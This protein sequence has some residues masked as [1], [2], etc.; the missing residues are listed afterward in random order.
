[1]DDED[2]VVRNHPKT[3]GKWP[4]SDP[5]QD[6]ERE[7]PRVIPISV[8]P[9]DSPPLSLEQEGHYAEPWAICVDCIHSHDPRPWW[10]RLFWQLQGRELYCLARPRDETISPVTGRITY[11]NSVFSTPSKGFSLPH[12]R[13]EDINLQGCCETFKKEED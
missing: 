7:P 3:E 10:R 12:E 1:M 9:Y 6:L 11:V 4:R 2:K 13:C 8:N 5:L